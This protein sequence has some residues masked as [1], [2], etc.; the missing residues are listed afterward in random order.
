MSTYVRWYIH[1]YLYV[2]PCA[3]MHVHACML[4]GEKGNGCGVMHLKLFT[5]A[6]HLHQQLHFHISFF[7]KEVVLKWDNLA[8]SP[9]P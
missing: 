9:T 7:N 2:C 6:N 1:A 4:K 5:Q 8:K 3:C